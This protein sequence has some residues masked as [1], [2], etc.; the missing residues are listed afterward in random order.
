MHAYIHKHTHTHI[1][2]KYT[3]TSM[4]IC[5]SDTQSWREAFR[6]GWPTPVDTLTYDLHHVDVIVY[7]LHAS[8]TIKK[9]QTNKI[10]YNTKWQSTVCDFDSTVCGFDSTVCDAIPAQNL[11]A[12][13]F[14]TH[15]SMQYG[16]FAYTQRVQMLPNIP[17]WNSHNY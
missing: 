17:Y 13:C 10:S 14:P 1:Y 12:L 9:R 6:V 7:L 3:H 2:T 15:S 8:E 4:C 16:M 11:V 5:M